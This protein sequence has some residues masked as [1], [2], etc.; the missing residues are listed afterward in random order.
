MSVV[1][2]N[3]KSTSAVPSSAPTPTADIQELINQIGLPLTPGKSAR[4]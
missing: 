1:G 4:R 3:Q 2:Q